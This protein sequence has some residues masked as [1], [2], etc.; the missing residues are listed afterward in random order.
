MK[1]K[2]NN[3]NIFGLTS[4]ICWGLDTVLI[5]LVLLMSPF[6]RPELIFLAPFLSSFLHDF[7]SGIWMI[8]I[9]TIRGKM[10]L[11]MRAIKTRNSKIVALAAILGG[12]MGMTGY[13][14]AVKY[15]GPAYAAAISA[16]YPVI[17]AVI[18]RIFLKEKLS[19]KSYIGL[20]IS[21]TAIAILGYDSGFKAD[22]FLLGFLFAI[23]GVLG[24][25]LECVICS[26]GMKGE[27][28]SSDIA[29]Q[30][31]QVVSSSTYFIIILPLIG[32]LKYVPTV[33]FSKAGLLILIT[34][35]IG[36]IS[37]LFYYK[38]IDKIGP[39]RAMGMNITYCIW[40][41]IFDAIIL[42]NP[43]TFK[44]VICSILVLIGT[45]LGAVPNEENEELKGA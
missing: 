33:V 23:L 38:A 12:P 9:M 10:G 42:N 2:Y 28:I 5:G 4:G 14:L 31:R 37:Y 20:V 17:G 25:S 8:I 18:A 40:A 6:N 27:E 21:I 19:N 45:V 3:G 34:A 13:L 7:F 32:G 1:L 41:I 11:V 35:L 43:I 36:T 24:W 44:L 16:I 26:Y 39:T 29:L 22:N 30:I 15:I